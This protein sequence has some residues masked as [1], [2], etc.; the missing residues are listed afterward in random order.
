[1][2]VGTALGGISCS[3]ARGPVVRVVLADISES[4]AD[5]DSVTSKVSALLRPGDVLIAFDS[6]PRL[7]GAAR[8]DTLAEL[9]QV[10]GPGDLAAGLIAAMRAAR[11]V[12]NTADSVEIAVVSAFAREEWSDAVMPVRGG[13]PG[14]LTLIPVAAAQMDSIGTALLL[15]NDDDPLWAT[16]RLAGLGQLAPDTGK[17]VELR[18]L[19]DSMSGR[20]S[21]FARSGGVVL[22]W[23]RDPPAGLTLVRRGA[24]A[25]GPWT[26]VL[27]LSGWDPAPGQTIARWASGEPAAT[28]VRLGEGCIRNV[29]IAVPPAGD[30]ALR[31][32]LQRLLRV[33]GSPCEWMRDT[34]RVDRERLAMLA[35]TRGLAA[36]EAI[37][38]Q[39]SAKRN[40]VT[41]WLLAGAVVLFM[42]ELV[43][44]RSVEKAS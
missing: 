27:P 36:S 17:G 24:V 32:G 4:I 20:D 12:A 9:P 1:M 40:D 7:L 35:G 37:D 31:P 33:L 23:P 10:P 15:A 43:L 34:R 8:A 13:W 22:W 39:P 5:R 44:R 14:R 25:A 18:V 38:R 11:D 41:K 28:Q 6:V 16:G 29:S 30:V 21:A 2:L 3:P 42:G 26:E 19:R